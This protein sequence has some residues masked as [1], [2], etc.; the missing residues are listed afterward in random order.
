MSRQVADLI[1]ETLQAIG[2]ITLALAAGLLAAAVGA[3]AADEPVRPQPTA[4]EHLNKGRE[5][6]YEA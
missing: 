3:Q 5:L 2:V 6:G 4:K 1:A